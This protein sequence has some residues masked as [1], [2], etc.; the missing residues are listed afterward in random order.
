MKAWMLYSQIKQLIEK[1]WQLKKGEKYED[2]IK[3]LCNIL[4]L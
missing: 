1:Y 4:K 2:F 3:E